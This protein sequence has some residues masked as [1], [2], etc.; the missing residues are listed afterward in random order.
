M[1][2]ERTVFGRTFRVTSLWLWGLQRA[3]GV[4]L[5]PLV[6]LH[7]LSPSVAKHAGMNALLLGLVLAHG[8]SG[9]K[10]LAT[11]KRL[12]ALYVVGA[13]GWFAVVALF[14]ILVV[15]G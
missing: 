9:I 7:M 5:G 10:R 15:I 3:S 12:N 13:I 11:I 8:Y 6:A 1:L 2:A 14:G 4:L